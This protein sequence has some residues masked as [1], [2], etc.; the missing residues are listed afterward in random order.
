MTRTLSFKVTVDA[1][2]GVNRADLREY[3]HDAVGGWKGQFHPENPLFDLDRD[4]VSVT[5]Y[6]RTNL[7]THMRDFIAERALLSEAYNM[8]GEFED[9]GRH[10]PVCE[11]RQ[12]LADYLRGKLHTSPAPD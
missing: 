3:I 7:P 6:R 11:L 4:G 10:H 5:Q 9:D 12:R 8:L 2:L 1:P